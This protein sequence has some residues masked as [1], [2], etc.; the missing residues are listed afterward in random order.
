LFLI[1]VWA[2]LAIMVLADDFNV[3]TPVIVGLCA[4]AA[5]VVGSDAA[6][7]LMRSFRR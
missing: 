6:I 5:Y 2:V 4:I 7:R 1:A 3:G